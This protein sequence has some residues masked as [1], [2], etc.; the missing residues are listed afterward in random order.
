[1]KA[2]CGLGQLAQSVKNESQICIGGNELRV[3]LYRITIGFR[4]G[5]E[6]AFT[7]EKVSEAGNRL[8]RAGIK[9]E[10]APESIDR[11]PKVAEVGKDQTQV[12]VNLVPIGVERQGALVQLD[13]RLEGAT[14]IENPCQVAIKVRSTRLESDCTLVGIRGSLEVPKPFLRFAEMLVGFCGR[15]AKLHNLPETTNRELNLALGKV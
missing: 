8:G 11:R 12:V 4:R 1:M 2:I 14:L 9:F 3:E 5:D 13:R 10:R 15:G 7:F 6:I